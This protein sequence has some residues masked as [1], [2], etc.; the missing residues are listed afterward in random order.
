M[1]NN[2][3]SEFQAFMQNP[4]QALIQKQIPKEVASDPDKAIQYLLDSGRASQSQY[5]VAQQ[6]MRMISRSHKGI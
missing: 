2:I 4:V 3:L 6:Y 5:N 1:S